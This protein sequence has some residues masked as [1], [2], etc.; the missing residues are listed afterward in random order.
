M[1]E[2]DL[3]YQPL[4][5]GAIGRGGA[6]TAQV[7][8]DHLY[9]FAC[10]AEAQSALHQSVL[11]SRRF[12]V[13]LDLS[14]SRLP[15]IDDGQTIPVAT[16]HLFRKSHHAPPRGMDTGHARRC[17]ERER[18]PGGDERD[19]PAGRQ[20]VDASALAASPRSWP[21]SGASAACRLAIHWTN[22]SNATRPS[23]G[24]SIARSCSTD[25]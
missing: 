16:L 5:A 7:V 17:P 1:P 12:L 9:A 4:E 15:D 18:M 22:V 19:G 25:A 2:P 21:L 3:G 8:I 24:P 10:P 14:Q 13:L 6:G 20:S 23:R 11:Q